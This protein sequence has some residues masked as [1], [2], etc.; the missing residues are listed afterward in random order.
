MSKKIK[1]IIFLLLSIVFVFS[2]TS[3]NS[4]SDKKARELFETTQK[5]TLSSVK[6]ITATTN[7]TLFASRISSDYENGEIKQVYGEVGYAKFWCDINENLEYT[8][9]YNPDTENF[10]YKKIF[11]N[12]ETIMGDLTMYTQYNFIKLTKDNYQTELNF[13]SDGATTCT[14]Y[15]IKYKE[16]SEGLKVSVTPTIVKNGKTTS[17]TLDYYFTIGNGLF[18][19]YTLTITDTINHIQG[20]NPVQ[21]TV[22]YNYNTGTVPTLPDAQW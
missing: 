6:G 8:E 18:K 10:S 13:L 11:L 3:C 7:I 19:S 16:T 1:K 9:T 12:S 4:K 17:T 22:T 2:F 15:S 5:A 14:K 21:I 20:S